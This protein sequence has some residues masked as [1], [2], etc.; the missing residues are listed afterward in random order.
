MA[1]RG[2][3]G[4]ASGSSCKKSPQTT[5]CIVRSRAED[6]RKNGG[7]A[8]LPMLYGLPAYPGG[9]GVLHE[10]GAA[11]RPRCSGAR[12]DAHEPLATHV[13]LEIRHAEVE[14]AV[15]DRR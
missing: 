6:D 8:R 13:P 9:L 11:S 3:R 1:S 2:F 5:A 12:S 14:P 7:F 4:I 15:T 10:V